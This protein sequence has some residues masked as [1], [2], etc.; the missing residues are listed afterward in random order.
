MAITDTISSL[1]ASALGGVFDATG[2][3][4][5][6]AI[7]GAVNTGV[8]QT[9]QEYNATVRQGLGTVLSDGANSLLN[10]IG[11]KTENIPVVGGILQNIAQSGITSA[12]TVFANVI[13]GTLT[14]ENLPFFGDY[15]ANSILSNDPGE[16]GNIASG[17]N[18]LHDT[19]SSYFGSGFGDLVSDSVRSALGVGGGSSSSAYAGSSIVSKS[20]FAASLANNFQPKFKFLYIV[21]IVFKS[22]F[23]VNTKTECGEMDQSFT[24]LIKHFERPKLTIEHDEVNYYSFRTMVPKRTVYQPINIDIHDDIQSLAMNFLVSY[25]R[26]IS[27]IFN[28]TDSNN[29]DKNSMNFKKL[30]SSYALQTKQNNINIIDNI[31]VHHLYDV[32]R[33]MDTYIFHNPKILEVT[34]G[35]WDMSE[36]TEG[37]SISLNIAYDG[38]EIRSGIKSR[39]PDSRLGLIDLKQR[40]APES[41]SSPTSSAASRDYNTTVQKKGNAYTTDKI[42]D[43]TQRVA[44]VVPT[45]LKALPSNWPTDPLQPVK[46]ILGSTTLSNI[47]D[48]LT[49]L[50]SS[51]KSSTSLSPIATDLL[52]PTAKSTTSPRIYDPMRDGP[53]SSTYESASFGNGIYIP[54]TTQT[55]GTPSIEVPTQSSVTWN[56]I[57]DLLN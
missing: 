3:A 52:T 5:Q 4:T 55:P 8:T 43:I 22:G 38:L 12:S 34:L 18:G 13:D 31:K 57:H 40:C 29:Y 48:G 42:A 20:S 45:V 30:T 6:A 37:S 32:N 49:F 24:M 53:G 1:G 50:N 9:I 15:N 51:G 11:M 19:L 16:T 25:L 26:R 44:S 28:E 35:D 46:D 21:E 7:Q 47:N 17:I 33:T 23:G 10:K 14:L 56:W 2:A 54:N 27:P 36:G 41:K 39:I